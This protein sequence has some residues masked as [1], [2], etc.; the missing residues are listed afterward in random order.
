MKW[1]ARILMLTG[2]SLLVWFSGIIIQTYLFQSRAEVYLSN[3][4]KIDWH[5]NSKIPRL[6]S[7]LDFIGQINIPRIGLAAII[8]EGSDDRSLRLGVGHISGTALPGEQG[9]IALAGH[10]DTFFRSLRKIRP[11]DEI[12]L[13]TFNNSATYRV[14]WVKVVGPGDTEVIKPHSSSLLTLVTCY[15]F[16]F[17]GAAPER[18]IVRAHQVAG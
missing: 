9:N 16:Y 5:S 2:L 13:T 11:N 12:R 14:D 18:Y 17:V 15:P 6:Q 3:I 7:N 1:G 10:R 4:S 8:V